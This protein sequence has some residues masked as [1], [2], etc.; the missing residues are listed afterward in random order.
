MLLIILQEI[1]CCV[2]R[3]ALDE[4]VEIFDVDE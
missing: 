3:L 4:V 2:D 1:P